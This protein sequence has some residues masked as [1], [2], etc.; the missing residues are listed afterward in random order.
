MFS[1]WCV[2]LSLSYYTISP[3]LPIPTSTTST[4]TLLFLWLDKSKFDDINDGDNVCSSAY[5]FVLV[6]VLIN[7]STPDARHLLLS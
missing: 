2:S 6:V 1:V 7:V 5:Y 3:P 4:L